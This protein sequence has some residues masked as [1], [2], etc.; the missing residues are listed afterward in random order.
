MSGI[1]VRIFLGLAV[2]ALVLAAV[3]SVLLVTSQSPS[4]VSQDL[5]VY[6]NR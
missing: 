2:A 1:P 3:A 5:I 6:G 4:L